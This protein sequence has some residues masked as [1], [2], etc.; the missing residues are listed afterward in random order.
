MRKEKL[1]VSTVSVPSNFLIIFT[2]LLDNN[3]F[4]N[5]QYVY[6]AR[7]AS[8][9]CSLNWEPLISRAGNSHGERTA[10]LWGIKI[11][12]LIQYNIIPDNCLVTNSKLI[13]DMHVM[14]QCY[15]KVVERKKKCILPGSLK[16]HLKCYILLWILDERN[17]WKQKKNLFN[18]N[19]KPIR[20]RCLV[21][22]VGRVPVRWG[23]I[24]TGFK[25]RLDQHSGFLNNWDESVANGYFF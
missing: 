14:E 4:V 18:S 8:Y 23:G 17:C 6:D 25:P 15:Q 20:N 1:V 11:R 21:S 24:V 10:L 7:V 19:S 2:L 9:L 3:D 12:I 13:K 5:M 22:S 16:V